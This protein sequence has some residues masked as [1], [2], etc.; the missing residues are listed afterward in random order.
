MSKKN[1]FKNDLIHRFLDHTFT[2]VPVGDLTKVTFKDAGSVTIAEQKN[3]SVL[4]AYRSIR[5]DLL[6]GQNPDFLSTTSERDALVNI[7][8]GTEILNIT[9]L[10]NQIF[11][12]S[13]WLPTGGETGG[14]VQLALTNEQ[15]TDNTETT[16]HTLPLDDDS[17]YLVTA[18]IMGKKPDITVVAGVT[19]ECTAKR[20]GGGSVSIEGGTTTLHDGKGSGANQWDAEFNVSGNDLLVSITGQNGMTIDWQASVKYLKF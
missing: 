13:I 8:R 16:V 10:E 6:L 18:K 20:V 14:M 2:E 17:V 12:G 11:T 4:D 5:E 19:I 1:L 15:T 3:L 7:D 9:V